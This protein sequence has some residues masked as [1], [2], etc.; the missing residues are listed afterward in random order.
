MGFV[1]ILVTWLYMQH[2][3]SYL[4]FNHIR[5]HIRDSFLFEFHETNFKTR[6]LKFLKKI[7]DLTLQGFVPSLFAYEANT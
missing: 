2:T 7:N 3:S 1:H 5:K 6:H 4:V